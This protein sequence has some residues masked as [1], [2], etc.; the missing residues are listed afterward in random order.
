MF[1]ALLAEFHAPASALVAL[2]PLVEVEGPAVVLRS[3][4]V[5]QSLAALER[6]GRRARGALASHLQ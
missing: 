6:I 5:A 4:L 1:D 2:P 3:L